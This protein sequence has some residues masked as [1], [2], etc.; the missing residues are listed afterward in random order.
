MWILKVGIEKRSISIQFPPAPKTSPGRMSEVPNGRCG[1]AAICM[2]RPLPHTHVINKSIRRILLGFHRPVLRIRPN[3]LQLTSCSAKNPGALSPPSF[4][5]Q[6]WNLVQ[7]PSGGHPALP[8]DVVTTIA[9]TNWKLINF[10]GCYSCAVPYLHIPHKQI[11]QEFVLHN[12]KTLP[13]R[14]IGLFRIVGLEYCIGSE[15]SLQDY[16]CNVSLAITPQ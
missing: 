5:M 13:F 6:P 15:D 1:Y 11:L 2:Y 3:L 14:I 10:M 9:S 8:F 4:H 12:K 16:A 7:P